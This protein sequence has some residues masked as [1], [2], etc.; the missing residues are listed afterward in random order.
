MTDISKLEEFPYINPLMTWGQI[1][2]KYPVF[3]CLTEDFREDYEYYRQA[4]LDNERIFHAITFLRDEFSNNLDDF[5]DKFEVRSARDKIRKLQPGLRSDVW[6]VWV[7][8]SVAFI[9]MNQAIINGM[10]SEYLRKIRRSLYNVGRYKI[11]WNNKES[12]YNAGAR[13][14]AVRARKKEIALQIV[15]EKCKDGYTD[16]Y[17]YNLFKAEFDKLYPSSKPPFSKS[18]FSRRDSGNP[19]VQAKYI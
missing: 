12:V 5:N 19:L 6:L 17:N 14:N 15:R 7:H 11:E 3:E 1:I 10:S 16:E 8:L 2:K 9:F 18:A 13:G 4:F